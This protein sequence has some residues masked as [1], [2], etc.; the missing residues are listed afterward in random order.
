MAAKEELDELLD[1]A[2][3][4]VKLAIES[5]KSA[6]VDYGMAFEGDDDQYTEVYKGKV[7]ECLKRLIDIKSDLG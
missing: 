5:L 3:V 7:R 1:E 6:V 4:S 2:R